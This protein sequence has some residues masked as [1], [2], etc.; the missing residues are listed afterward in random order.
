[1]SSV[2]KFGFIIPNV[3]EN[4]KRWQKPPKGKLLERYVQII[5]EEGLIF[6]AE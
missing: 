6:P 1:M 4:K 5:G 3:V 2:I